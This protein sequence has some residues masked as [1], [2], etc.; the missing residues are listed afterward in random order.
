M[1]QKQYV[2]IVAEL[3]QENPNK[4]AAHVGNEHITLSDLD[5][6]SNQMARVY[7]SYGAGFD[8]IITL[9]MRNSIELLVAT[10]A[11]WKVGARP[12]PVSSSMPTP[13]LRALVENG[14]PK[15]ILRN[16]D[17]DLGFPVLPASFEPGEDVSSDPLPPLP[18]PGGER[19]LASGGSTG[20]PKL[21]LPAGRAVF[22]P[23]GVLTF[24]ATKY[25]TVVPGPLYHAIPFS[26]TWQGIFRGVTVVIMPRFDAEEFLALVQKHKADHLFIV[27]TMMLRIWKLPEEVRN[28]YDVSSLETVISGGAPLPAWLMQAWIDWLGPDVMNEA[29]GP[30]ERIGGTY[31][32][33]REWLEHPGSVGRALSFCDMRVLDE[34][35]NDCAPGVMGEVYLKPKSGPGTTYEYRGA[36][37]ERRSDGWETVGDMGYLDEDGY[38]YLGDR[39]SDMILVNGRNLYPAEIEGAIERF[40]GV[41]SCAVIGLPNAEDEQIAYA[42]VDSAGEVIDEEELASFL[43]T[44]ITGY[45]IPK[46]FEFVDELLRN[47]AGKVRRSA[48]REDRVAGNAT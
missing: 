2:E 24:F 22:D 6:R 26:E 23:H 7:Q 4:I 32:T 25:A 40:P 8:D 18:E 27:P 30:S 41:R 33:G 31:I 20:R 1:S 12:N 3:A 47:D 34:H 19:A 10:L 13:E 39:R 9:A 35:G 14:K 28:K 36:S 46:K 43:G 44:Q 37:S 21:I 38:L 48:L 16:G 42:I 11:C 15:L 29:F 17:E 5:R 45:K